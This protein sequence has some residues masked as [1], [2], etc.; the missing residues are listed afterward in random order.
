MN[1]DME[2]NDDIFDT[3]NKC[4][5]SFPPHLIFFMKSLGFTSFRA[6]SKIDTKIINTIE[7]TIRPLY[8]EPK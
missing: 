5:I 6:I 1:K 8:G 3:L 4:G 7:T 2:I